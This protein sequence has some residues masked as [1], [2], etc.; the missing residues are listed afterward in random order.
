MTWEC[1]NIHLQVDGTYGLNLRTFVAVAKLRAA[2]V[3]THVGARIS[4][5]R[6][7]QGSSQEQLAD[8]LDVTTQW[9][10]RVENGHENL[11]IETLTRIANALSVQVVELFSDADPGPKLPARVPRRDGKKPRP[12]RD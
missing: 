4:E 5:L 6:R 7:R 9:L 8:R 11:T 10:S 2:Q 12:F 3:K 1:G